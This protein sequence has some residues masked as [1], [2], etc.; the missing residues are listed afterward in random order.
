M[1]DEW[2][3]YNSEVCKATGLML[4][5]WTNDK[6]CFVISVFLDSYYDISCSLEMEESK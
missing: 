6:L 1:K 3:L 2:F 4:Y 5:L